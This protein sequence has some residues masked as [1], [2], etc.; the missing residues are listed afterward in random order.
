MIHQI[1]TKYRVTP[2]LEDVALD[3]KANNVKAYWAKLFIVENDLKDVH[4][5]IID[6]ILFGLK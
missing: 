5:H 2:S 6:S 4:I 1:R 3:W